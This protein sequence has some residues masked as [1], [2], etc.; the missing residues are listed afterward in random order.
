MGETDDAMTLVS[1]SKHPM[2]ILYADYAN[3]MKAMANRARIEMVKTGNLES[4]PSAKKIYKQEVS[5]LEAK[6]N[7]ALKNTPKERAATRLAAAEIKRKKESNP[8][9]KGDD[10]RKAS[11]R[12]VSKYRTEVGS[13]SRRD[14]SIKITDREWEAIQAGAISENKLKQI[15][16]NSDPDV[17]RERAMPKVGKT[18]NTAQVN[19]IKALSNSNFT[20]SQIAEKMNLSPSTVSKYLKGAN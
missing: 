16:N 13:V 2:E 18:L 17:L 12:A 7:D 20:L 15:L 11:Q 1:S 5:S 14:R 9:L 8:D 4:N 3:S 6:L 19:R 10:L